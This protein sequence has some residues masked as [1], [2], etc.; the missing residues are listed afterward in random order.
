MRTITDPN[1]MHEWAD[2]VRRR[3]SRIGFVPTMGALHAGHMSLV[4]SALDESDVVVV[5]IF[6]NPMQFEGKSD[7]DSYPRPIEDDVETC[8]AAG[9]DVVYAPTTATM[10]PAGFQTRVTLGP[11]TESMEG[12]ARVGHFD[13][14]ATIVTKLFNVVQPHR[15][16]FGEKDF[17]QLTIIKQMTTD[18]DLGIEIVGHPIVREHDGLAM[19]SRNTRLDEAER[20]AAICLPRAL[21]VAAAAATQPLCTVEQI[22]DAAREVVASEPLASIDYVTVFDAASLQPLTDVTPN[23]RRAGKVRIAGAVRFGD[24]RLIDNRDLFAGSSALPE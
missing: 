19:S 18:L 20:T 15:A 6:V 7:L 2:A 22:L 13:G 16:L 17:Q 24:V 12:A 10:Y 1:H 9:V 5:S 23:Q 8:A 21:D 14:V 11:L 4:R 3:G